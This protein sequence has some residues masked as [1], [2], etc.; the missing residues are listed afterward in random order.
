MTT[1]DLKKRIEIAR[2][3]TPGEWFADPRG[4]GLIR[5]GPIQ[6]WARGSGQSQL[7][8]ATGQEWMSVEEHNANAAHIA[9][10]HPQ[11]VIEMC[12]ELLRLRD[13]AAQEARRH[14]YVAGWVLRE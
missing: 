8:L 11:A 3:A 9:A 2:A 6:H 12:E 7:A 13:N 10:N 4:G 1:D 14:C 5:G